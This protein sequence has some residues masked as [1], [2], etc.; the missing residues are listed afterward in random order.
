[1]KVLTSVGIAVAVLL[2][3]VLLVLMIIL[4]KIWNGNVLKSRTHT[5]QSPLIDR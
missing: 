4:V 3:L 5:V 2:G 1:M